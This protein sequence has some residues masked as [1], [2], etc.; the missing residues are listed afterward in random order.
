MSS[1]SSAGVK[2]EP[3]ELSSLVNTQQQSGRL[4]QLNR[5]A[6]LSVHYNTVNNTS[7]STCAHSRCSYYFHWFCGQ[8]TLKKIPQQNSAES[9]AGPTLT[10]HQLHG[11]FAPDS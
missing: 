5:C 6:L 4:N 9:M 2:A 8:T 11:G 3:T 7:F 1:D 10:F